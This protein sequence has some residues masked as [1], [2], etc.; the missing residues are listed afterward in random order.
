MSERRIAHIS[1]THLGYRAY[2]KTDSDGRN[3]RSLDIESA[4]QAVVD[5]DLHTPDLDLIV[6][7]GDVFHQSRPSWSAIRAFISQTKRLESLG[8]PIIV[9]AG[10]HDT[11]QLRT[12]GTVFSVLELA[13]PGVR[14]VSGYD[15][16]AIDLAGIGLHVVAV[17]H[18]R[19]VSGPIADIWLPEDRTNILL[20]HGLVPVLADSPRH[21]L[22]EVQIS[23]DLLSPAY[24]AI[25]LGHFHMHQRVAQ[26]AWYAGSTERIGWNDES[27]NPC[28]S[29]VSI[30]GDGVATA[31]DRRITVRQMITLGALDCAGAGGK[32]IAEQVMSAAVAFAHPDAMVRI[33]LQV[34]ERKDRRSAEAIIR[35][36]PANTFLC[37]QTYVRQDPAALFQDDGRS[38]RGA[39]LK[40]L[41]DMFLEFC[42]E[43]DWDEGFRN[44]FLERGHLAIARAIA[45][46]EP[47]TGDSE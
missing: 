37:L 34:A 18:G 42:G 30:D 9:I 3:Q 12:P 28:W 41:G 27:H 43:Q 35:R 21:E 47:Q 10:N 14:F 32:E 40:G 33:E 25:L 31:Q 16:E 45:E 2:L 8:V 17:P 22:G 11:P 24:A 29:L 15:H 44:R 13:L 6:H 4:Y 19:L 39:Q 38:D 20:T 23:E 36:D 5:D 1:D 7:T 26:N 46:A